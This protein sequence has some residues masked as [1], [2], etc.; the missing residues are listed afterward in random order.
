MLFVRCPWIVAH[1][2]RKN[3]ISS[4]ACQLAHSSLSISHICRFY[5]FFLNSIPYSI[6]IHVHAFAQKCSIRCC[7]L[8]RCDFSSNSLIRRH[9]KFKLFTCVSVIV[10]PANVCGVVRIGVV[11]VYPIRLHPQWFSFYFAFPIIH[12]GHFFSFSP[13]LCFAL[14]SSYTAIAPSHLLHPVFRKAAA[15]AAQ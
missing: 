4:V 13:S 1:L 2:L 9:R 3:I 7:V 10:L 6:L 14:L 5:I 11:H 15:A 8:C 12:N